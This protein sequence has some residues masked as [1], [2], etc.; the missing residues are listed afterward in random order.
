[1]STDRLTSTRR[2]GLAERIRQDGRQRLETSK[3]SAAEQLQEVAQALDRAGA[4]LDQ[5]QPTLASYTSHLASGVGNFATRLRE[6]SFD[7]LLEDTRQIARRNPALFM[8]GGVALGIA[9]ARFLRASSENVSSHSYS[10]AEDYGATGASPASGEFSG[11]PSS[12]G[13]GTPGSSNPDAGRQSS[14][15]G[16]DMREVNRGVPESTADFDT[17]GYAPAP[18]AARPDLEPATRRSDAP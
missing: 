9:L 13:A 15:P 5:S 10:Q 18:G 17:A 12:Y 8:A 11:A 16:A 6:G 4:Q 7:E 3:R 1:M 14:D 2:G